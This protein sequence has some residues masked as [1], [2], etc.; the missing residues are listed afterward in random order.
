MNKTVIA[1][2]GVAALITAMGVGGAFALENPGP[3]SAPTITESPEA[4]EPTETAEPTETPEATPNNEHGWEM[5]REHAGSHANG[6]AAFLRTEA[7][8][9]EH[10]EDAQAGE[11]EGSN[12]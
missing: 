1:T 12:E 3:S 11:S 7:P 5:A 9:S 2:A 6:N 10:G 4:V 8:S